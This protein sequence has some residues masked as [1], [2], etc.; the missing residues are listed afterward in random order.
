MF[1]MIAWA[2]GILGGILLLLLLLIFLL[3]CLKVQVFVDK[4]PGS[5]LRLLLQY[6]ILRIPILPLPEKKKTGK[7]P[8]KPPDKKEKPEAPAKKKGIP[9]FL[10]GL[11]I[12]DL[13]CLALDTLLA[14]KNRLVIRRLCVKVLIATGDAG[15]TGILLGRSAAVVGMILPLLEQNFSIPNFK[16]DIDGDFEAEKPDTRA[17]VGLTLYM[18]PV[19]AAAILLRAGFR[20][21]L[22]VLAAR[23]REKRRMT[24][25]PAGA[26]GEMID[27]QTD[28]QNEKKEN[29]T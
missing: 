4:I 15:K 2:A 14:L 18:R 9:P 17:A 27:P 29:V 23:R 20:F 19:F 7:P 26:S 10:K 16:V 5:P 24:A 28:K 12:G 22:M 1:R 3:L 13:I 25:A 8:K 11:D 6:G 21:L